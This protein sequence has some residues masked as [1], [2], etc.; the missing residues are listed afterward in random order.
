MTNN[1]QW[2][3]DELDKAF[4][5]NQITSNQALIFV[6]DL[7]PDEYFEI[8]GN[9]WTL[10]R[11][12]PVGFMTGREQSILNAAAVAVEITF[13][14]TP[15]D[16]LNWGNHEDNP[17]WLKDEYIDK[18]LSS[19][20][21]DQLLFQISDERLS[22]CLTGRSLWRKAISKIIGELLEKEI[23]PTLD[24]VEEICRS[25]PIEHEILEFRDESAEVIVNTLKDGPKH[26]DY[27]QSF[28]RHIRKVL[29]NLNDASR[30]LIDEEFSFSP[31][32]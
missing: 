12:A 29:L 1:K 8:Q 5:N 16:F 23:V 13:P 22:E 15:T 9:A 30:E 26:I 31:R 24:L 21:A 25:D 19:S 20:D 3:I 27:T 32:Q 18:Y 17:L 6:D 2:L 4:T 7:H 11:T 14:V 28:A 10:R